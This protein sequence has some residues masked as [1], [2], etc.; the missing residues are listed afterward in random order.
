MRKGVIDVPLLHGWEQRPFVT[1]IVPIFT[2]P[3]YATWLV[4]HLTFSQIC[5]FP[6][7]V[8]TVRKGQSRVRLTFHGHNTEAHVEKLVTA[9]A[10][11]AQE[12]ADLESRTSTVQRIPKAARQVYSW[13]GDQKVEPVEPVEVY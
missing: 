11:W 1:P 3:Q 6:V 8:P 9:I 4:F 13:M 10:E 12:M 7:D 2:R 5:A